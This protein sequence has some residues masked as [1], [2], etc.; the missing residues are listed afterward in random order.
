MSTERCRAQSQNFSRKQQR[1]MKKTVKITEERMITLDGQMTIGK[2]ETGQHI[3]DFV[4]TEHAQV[5]PFSADCKVQMLGN[6]CMS[7][8][9]KPKRIRK[10]PERR[11]TRWSVSLGLDGK[12]RVY[13][14][15]PN[16]D[17]E[18]AAEL[19]EQDVTEIA[20]ALWDLYLEKQRK[21]GKQ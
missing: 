16:D 18:N 21:G 5:E 13:W 19:L 12:T 7:V 3:A 6:G 14:G 9:E 1:I 4:N 8:V 20:A 17:L 15:H 2:L 11:G 10:D